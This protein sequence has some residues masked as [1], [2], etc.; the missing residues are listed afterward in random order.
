MVM[1]DSFPFNTFEKDLKDGY[2]PEI[3]LQNRILKT[4]NPKWSLKEAREKLRKMAEKESGSV[5]TGFEKINS[6][7]DGWGRGVVCR[8]SS[9]FQL[10]TY[11]LEI[12]LQLC[13]GM[14]RN[15]LTETDSPVRWRGVTMVLYAKKKLP[16]PLS[17]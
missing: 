6:H 14:L 3:I 8:N 2:V 11:R 7:V 4:L 9:V 17:P 16:E 5:R 10:L 1:V 13:R 12:V 15:Y